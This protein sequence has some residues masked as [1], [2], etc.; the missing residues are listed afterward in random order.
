MA[1]PGVYGAKKC[2]SFYCVIYFWRDRKTPIAHRVSDFGH[3]Q[4]FFSNKRYIVL[5][6]AQQQLASYFPCS[7]IVAKFL[8]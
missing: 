3:A 4:T 2:L 8:F 1:D 5:S 7:I 6:A